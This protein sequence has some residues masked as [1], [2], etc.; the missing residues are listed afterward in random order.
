M[1]LFLVDVIQK[2]Y[3]NPVFPWGPPAPPAPPCATPKPPAPPCATPKP[4]SPPCGSKP[5]VPEVYTQNDG[6]PVVLYAYGDSANDVAPAKDS[7][8]ADYAAPAYPLPPVLPPP[9]SYPY[10]SYPASAP[11]A[12]ADSD[13]L[14]LATAQD[15]A[16][17]SVADAPVETIP[18]PDKPC[19]VETSTEVIH[20]PG[21]TFYHQ[22]GEILIN[23]PPTRLIINHAPYIIKPSPVVINSGHKTITNAYTKKILPS[24]IQLRPVIVRIVRPIEKK[25]L[26]D[27]PAAPGCKSYAST[28]VIPSPCAGSL[29]LADA[30]DAA[31][32]ESTDY[33]VPVAAPSYADLGLDA[34]SYGY[35]A[36]APAALDYQSLLASPV[37]I[38]TFRFNLICP[39][40]HMRSF[41]T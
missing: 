40:I 35:G 8:D 37:S 11:A 10:P 31:A 24:S 23:Q 30:Q 36:V 20:K 25:V 33:A 17:K 1:L 6:K 4:P 9:A 5:P 26:I 14:D 15:L 2:A 3:A 21:E 41:L 13:S 7:Y 16:D 27:K 29:A 19:K 22:P 34:S 38:F 12:P 18:A 39:T 28:P 32:A